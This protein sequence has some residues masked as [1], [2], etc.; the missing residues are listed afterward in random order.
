VRSPDRTLQR[1]RAQAPKTKGVGNPPK[2]QSNCEPHCV[3]AC[4][5]VVIMK[6][7]VIALS[8]LVL[9]PPSFAIAASDADGYPPGL[10]EHSPLIDPSH[11]A[12]QASASVAAHRFER[13]GAKSRRR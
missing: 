7:F 1:G 5:R 10:F 2:A 12:K 3:T 8:V 13:G 9:A 11:P 4:L 6:P